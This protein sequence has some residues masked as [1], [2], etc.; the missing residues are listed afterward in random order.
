MSDSLPPPVEPSTQPAN[1][2]ELASIRLSQDFG[3]LAGA[4]KH[5]THVPVGRP[6]K[7]RFFQVHPDPAYQV[8]TSVIERQGEGAYLLSSDMA[9]TFPDLERLVRLHL[10][11]TRHGSCGIWPVKLPLANGRPNAW[12]QSALEIAERAMSRWIR[13]ASNTDMGLY[14]AYEAKD[15]E[16]SPAWPEMSFNTLI[17]KAFADA[18]RFVD[19][20]EHPLIQE[21]EGRV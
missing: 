21:I 19:A 13:L 12:V 5:L 8:I 11:V 2:I 7:D 1:K 9:G 17:D 14:E 3:N 20:K 6:P 10:Y 15:L 18:G 16:V 4:V